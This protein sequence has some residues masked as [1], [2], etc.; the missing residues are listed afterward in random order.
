MSERKHFETAAHRAKAKLDF[1]THLMIYVLINLMLAG[2]NMIL[3]PSILWF[4]LPLVGWGVGLL[5]HG[6]IV[7][8]MGSSRLKEKLVRDELNRLHGS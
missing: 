7:F 2:L 6:L 4:L 3:S 8:V 1:Y 5:I